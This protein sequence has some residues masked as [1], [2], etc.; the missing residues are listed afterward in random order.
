MQRIQPTLRCT[1]T[2]LKIVCNE[3]S[4]FTLQQPP[5]EREKHRQAVLDVTA[6]GVQFRDAQWI[7]MLA[8]DTALRPGLGRDCAFLG[9]RNACPNQR[10][11]ENGGGMGI[12]EDFCSFIHFMG[13]P[14]PEG[15]HG[16]L[17]SNRSGGRPGHLASR[18]AKDKRNTTTV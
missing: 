17:I 18:A 4:K 10:L 6:P 15:S 8:S 7:G 1:R 12:L 11:L 3:W 16:D 14:S 2:Y 9:P 13:K 5:G